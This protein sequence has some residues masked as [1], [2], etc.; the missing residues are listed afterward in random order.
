MTEVK[1]MQTMTQ[2][3]CP[4]SRPRAL[5]KR[6]LRSENRL[7]KGRGG[8]SEENRSVG[9]VPAFLDCTT[10]QVYRSRFADG[11][12]APVHVLEGLPAHLLNGPS[13]MD[14]AVAAGSR[15][16]SGFL[17]EGRFYTRAEASR[18][19]KRPVEA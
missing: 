1:T 17:R 6:L 9:F 3:R 10:G 14:R 12:P 4:P 7:F 15:L 13:G 8:I 19:L 11:R 2:A 16:L 18:A 5:S